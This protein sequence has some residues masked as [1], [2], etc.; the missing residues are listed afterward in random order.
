MDPYIPI[1]SH[2]I[3]AG[4]L[5]AMATFALLE[6]K[7][8]SLI[9][10]SL[11]LWPLSGFL[12]GLL[13]LEPFFRRHHGS[14]LIM[15]IVLMACS[16]QALLVNIRKLS[17]WPSGSVW[18]G[19]ILIGIMFQIP[20][21]SVPEPVFQDFYRRLSGFVWMAIGI[22][23]VI[24]ER[25]VSDTSAVPVWIQLAYLQAALVASSPF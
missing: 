15:G 4:L 16:S 1:I 7:S 3:A 19:L 22:T 5:I 24:G 12:F 10:K 2:W 11:F 6:A 13:C 8:S 9:P 21:P 25:S 20:N 18:L 14:F 23:K 17:R